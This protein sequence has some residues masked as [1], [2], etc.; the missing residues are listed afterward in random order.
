MKDQYKTV[1]DRALAAKADLVISNAK[2]DH[3]SYIV[4][5]FLEN[6]ERVVRIYSTS[7]PRFTE[8]DGDEVPVF[9]SAD[10]VNAARDFLTKDDTILMVLTDNDLDLDLDEQG[11]HPLIRAITNMQQETNDLRGTLWIAK[12]PPGAGARFAHGGHWQVMDTG[13][14]RLEHDPDNQDA[15]VNFGSP[16][17]AG[18][19]ARIFNNVAREADTTKVVSA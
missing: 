13:A 19:L 6:A 10:V 8:V 4:A 7:L 15:H 17:I 2:P 16:E 5:K 11:E 1:I 14:Y 3:A 12:A 18:N 9:A